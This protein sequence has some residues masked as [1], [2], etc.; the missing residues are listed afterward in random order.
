MLTVK[1]LGLHDRDKLE[2][3]PNIHIF[4]EIWAR[5][6][7]KLCSVYTIVAYTSCIMSLYARAVYRCLDI[8]IDLSQQIV[9]LTA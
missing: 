9:V 5:K 7:K 6:K 1:L 4:Y 2:V 8:V 3:P